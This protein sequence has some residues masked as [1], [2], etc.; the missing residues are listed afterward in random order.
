MRLSYIY[1]FPSNNFDVRPPGEQL[2]ISKEFLGIRR[3]FFGTKCYTYY[4]IIMYI[5][6]QYPNS[7][8]RVIQLRLMAISLPESASFGNFLFGRLPVSDVTIWWTLLS[9]VHL[10]ILSVALGAGV[11]FSLLHWPITEAVSSG[12]KFRRSR[13]NEWK[14][15]V[16]DLS[17]ECIVRFSSEKFQNS[18]IMEFFFITKLIRFRR[19]WLMQIVI[20]IQRRWRAIWYLTLPIV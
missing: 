9:F 7:S 16:I 1:Y 14:F 17:N 2:F 3:N 19:D 12:K 5:F 20:H 4:N 15:P 11:F 18:L 8:I 13:V 10:S 6:E